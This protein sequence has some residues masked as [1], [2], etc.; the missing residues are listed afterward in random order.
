MKII[1]SCVLFLTLVASAGA[2]TIGYNLGSA[3]GVLGTSH[4]YNVSGVTVTAY[5]F[6]PGGATNLYG[7]NA[8]LTETGLG[9]TNDPSGQNE[10]TLGS[11][12]QLDIS[13]LLP[14]GYTTAAIFVNSVQSGEPWDL[15]ASNT[16][17]VLGTL[18]INNSLVAN[19]AVDVSSLLNFK[20][21][22]LTAH[23]GGRHHDNVLLGQVTATHPTNVP[24][25][26]T[27]GMLLGVALCGLGFLR[28]KLS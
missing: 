18:E 22:G 20:Y 3:T 6:G 10:I 25:S 16:L 14:K 17:G 1:L 24:D 12:V 21:L 2:N 26:G 11:F 28:R 4:P 13:Q 9:L 7:K 8:G 23:F 19:Q 15:F 5:G 27:T